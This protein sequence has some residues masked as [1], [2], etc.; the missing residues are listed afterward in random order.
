MRLP[1]PGYC[2]ADPGN[3]YAVFQPKPNEGFTVD[4]RAGGYR[5]EWIHPASGKITAQ[6]TVKAAGGPQ[7]F[8]APFADAAVLYLRK[9]SSAR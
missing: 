6:G 8:M 3:E 9:E 1:R 5:A 2:L 7:E 4:V